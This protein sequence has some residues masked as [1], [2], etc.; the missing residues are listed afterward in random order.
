MSSSSTA[1]F[2][3]AA[4][5]VNAI[6]KACSKI[7]QNLLLCQG[8]ANIMD[9]SGNIADLNSTGAG[10]SVTLLHSI[11][12]MVSYLDGRGWVDVDAGASS[13]DADEGAM[14]VKI[15]IKLPYNTN[16]QNS[17]LMEIY[18]IQLPRAL[19][20]P[21]NSS[22][23]P[24][25]SLVASTATPGDGNWA[26]RTKGNLYDVNPSDYV[27]ALVNMQQAFENVT[28]M[29]QALAVINA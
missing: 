11:A 20:R 19:Y 7:H 24:D 21:G 10:N 5:A 26:V 2:G 14:A 4:I 23:E 29:M 15:V 27:A 3:N 8:L 16:L 9:G 25:L 28:D 17:T 18:T 6:E 22:A 1:V 12:T 13:D